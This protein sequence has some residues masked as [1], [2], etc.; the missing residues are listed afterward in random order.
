MGEEDGWRKRGRKEAI[1]RRKEIGKHSVGGEVQ[2]V[3]VAG[4]EGRGR[5]SEAEEKRRVEHE[6][7]RRAGKVEVG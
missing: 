6:E 1:E 7:E 2:P 3:R 4:G 5:R